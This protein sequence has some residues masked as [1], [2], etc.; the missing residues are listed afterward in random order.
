VVEAVTEADQARIGRWVRV[1]LVLVALGLVAVFVIARSLRPDPSGMG[2]HRQLGLPPCMFYF[3]TGMPCPTCGMTTSFSH[4]MHGDFAAAVRAHPLGAVLA[5][6]GLIAVPWCL[7]SAIFGRRFGIKKYD[8]FLGWGTVIFLCVAFAVWG[9]RLGVAWATGEPWTVQPPAFPNGE[10]TP[11]ERG[12]ED[13]ADPPAPETERRG[14]VA[15]P[16]TA[17]GACG[18]ARPDAGRP[19]GVQYPGPLLLR[20]RSGRHG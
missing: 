8:A 11:G 17:L 7:A 19:D 10:Q 4:L 14:H 6:L 5:V 2:T 18:N 20:G 3:A 15:V 9:L 12:A 1:G 13:S 16:R